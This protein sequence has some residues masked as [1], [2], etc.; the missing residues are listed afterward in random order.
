MSRQYVAQS[1]MVLV[2]WFLKYLPSSNENLNFVVPQTHGKLGD[3]TISDQQI[4]V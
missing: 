2:Q 1:G 3:K 4:T